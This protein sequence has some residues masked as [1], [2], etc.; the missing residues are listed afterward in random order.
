M[1][2]LRLPF[3]QSRGRVVEENFFA[4]R[5]EFFTLL[6]SERVEIVLP[7]ADCREIARARQAQQGSIRL[8]AFEGNQKSPM[9]LR[10]LSD[11]GVNECFP[12][13]S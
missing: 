10:H 5:G 1:R 12:S 4:L 11:N 13:R 9:R 3:F 7:P 6:F 2:V 8:A